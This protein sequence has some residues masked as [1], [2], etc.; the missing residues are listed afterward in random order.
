MNNLHTPHDVAPGA[1]SVDWLAAHNLA[2]GEVLPKASNV[3][4]RDAIAISACSR[5]ST[6]TVALR[7]KE[8]S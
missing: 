4:A 3:V 1:A 5:A 8:Q 7:G 6:I 2:D